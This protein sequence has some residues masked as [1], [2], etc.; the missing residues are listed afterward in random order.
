MLQGMTDAAIQANDPATNPNPGPE[1][2]IGD[3]VTLHRGKN[4]GTQVEILGYSKTDDSYAVRFTDGTFTVTPA[5]NVKI[6]QERL[7]PLSRIVRAFQGVSDSR[8]VARILANLEPY[9]NGVTAK[10]A[11]VLGHEEQPA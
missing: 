2:R 6:P 7:V 5:K 4:A 10:V 8:D 1:F 11:E 3:T 9:A